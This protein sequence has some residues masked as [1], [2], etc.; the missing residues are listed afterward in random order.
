M[1]VWH[2]AGGTGKVTSVTNRG[3]YV[4]FAG[5]EHGSNFFELGRICLDCAIVFPSEAVRELHIMANHK[6]QYPYVG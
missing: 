3:I 1:E 5:P 2:S 4:A 6:Q